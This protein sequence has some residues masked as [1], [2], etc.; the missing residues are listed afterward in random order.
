MAD[1]FN[2]S[3]INVLDDIMMGWYNK[4]ARIFMY[5]GQKPHPFG[6]DCYTIFCRVISI[7]LR[8]H[9]VEGGYIPELLEP[10]MHSEIGRTVGLNIW[11]F[12]P[13]FSTVKYAVVDSVFCG[14]NG[15]VALAEKGFY[16][17]VFI[18]MCW[19][20]PKVFQGI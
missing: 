5:V 4:F 16:S 11:I 12:Q 2:A 8:A 10:N 18:K 20:W 17:G 19:S 1:E 15:I 6:N 13:L 3:L 7:F 14:E 9:T